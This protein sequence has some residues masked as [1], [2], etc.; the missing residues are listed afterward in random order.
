[1]DVLLA[2]HFAGLSTR[3]KVLAEYIWLGGSGS[4]LRSATKVLTS[5]PTC[6]AEVP[7]WTYDGAATG[8]EDGAC[9]LVYLK[10]RSIH[11]DPLRCAQA[12]LG[13]RSSCTCQLPPS[14]PA[15][16]LAEAHALYAVL[17]DRWNAA[18]VSGAQIN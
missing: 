15:T 7:L 18:S 3:G 12:T 4:D 13:K 17:C 2:N 16:A 10:A 14:G 1:M 9:S 6:P 5:K 11:P 8:Q